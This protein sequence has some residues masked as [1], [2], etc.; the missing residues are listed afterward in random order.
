MRFSQFIVQSVIQNGGYS[1]DIGATQVNFEEILGIGKCVRSRETLWPRENGTETST[2]PTIS[3]IPDK[4]G[5]DCTVQGVCKQGS[6]RSRQQVKEFCYG[7]T[8]PHMITRIEF[9][10]RCAEIFPPADVISRPLLVHLLQG[11]GN[12]MSTDA[13]T[14]AQY[15]FISLKVSSV[16][17]QVFN[18]VP[19][20]QL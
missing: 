11:T 3:R 1:L 7:A 20:R 6:G 4:F 9:A 2:R 19:R 14:L 5:A 10:R 16:T 8:T 18:T 12:L 15:I 13:N 17:A